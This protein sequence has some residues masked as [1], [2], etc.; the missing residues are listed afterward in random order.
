MF[1]AF[2]WINYF[3]T[4]NKFEKM[5]QFVKIMHFNNYYLTLSI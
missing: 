5:L 2:L 1:I 4:S 3:F